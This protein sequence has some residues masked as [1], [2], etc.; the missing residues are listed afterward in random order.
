MKKFREIGF[1]NRWFVRTE[2]EHE[3]G[4]ES[5]EEGFTKPFTLRSVYIRAWIGKKV[6]IMDTKDGIKL[7]SKDESKLKLILGFYGY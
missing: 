1:G 5:E 3:D 6:L 2:Y 7:M 4:T